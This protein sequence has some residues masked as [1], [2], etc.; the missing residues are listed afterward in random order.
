MRRRKWLRWVAIVAVL[1]FAASAVFSRV[2]QTA[3]ARRY[4]ITRLAASFGRP[5]EVAR[6]DFSLLDGARL[7]AHSLTVSED[8]DFGNEYF[9]RAETL[10]A[11]LRW[12][13]LLSGR[14]EFGSLN[15]LRSSLNLV[16]DAEGHWNIER[17]LPPASSGASRP[18]FVGP[19]A[20]SSGG[21]VAR[22]SRID[23][24][25]GRINFKQRDDKSPFALLDVAGRVERDNAGHWQLDL[26]ARPMRAGTGLQ[27]IGMLRLRGTIAGT[28]ARLQPADLNLTWRAASAAD[29]LRLARQDDYGIRGELALDLN[30]RVGPTAPTSD[31]V[32]GSGGAQWSISGVA[33]LTGIHAW[34]LPGRTTDPAVNISL[35]AGWR[36]GEARAQ[37]RKLLVE[38]QGSH[39]EGTGDVDWARGLRPQFHIAS[40]TLGLQDV[41]SWYRAFNPEVADDLRAE[42]SLGVDVTLGGWPIQLQQG[43]IASAGGTLATKS[44]PAPIRI[45]AV[46]AG[47]SHGG[48]DFTPTE[49]SFAPVSPN[50]AAGTDSGA[51]EVPGTFLLRGSISPH[52]SGAFHWPPDWNFFIEG[53]TSRVQDWLALSAA[54]AQPVN[55][56]WTAEGGLSIKLRGTHR[57][58]LPATVWL[59]AMDFRALSLSPAYVNQPVRLLKAHV[60][61]MPAQQTITLSEAEAL[62][63]TWHGTLSRKPAAQI[64]ADSGAAPH[65]QWT[66][67]LT[68]DHLDTAELD[69]WLGPRAR[70]G[71][72]A[73]ITSFGSAAAGTPL[74]GAVTAGLAAQGRLRVAEIVMTPLRLEQFDGEVDLDGRTVKVRKATADFFGGKASGTFDASLISDPTYDFQGRFDRVNLGQLGRASPLLDSRIAGTSSGT[75]SLSTHGVGREALFASMEG[76]GTID[77]RNAEIHGLDFTGVFRGS[78]DTQDSSS[79]SFASIAGVFQIQNRGITLS[80]FVLNHSQGRLQADGR[81]DFSHAL[82]IRIVRSIP[83]AGAAPAS[84]APSGFLL[85]GTIENPKLV[86]ATPST[87]PAARPSSR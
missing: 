70:P 82:N 63:A 51:A 83:Q 57:T 41:L 35:D 56:G 79:S 45:G 58:D 71:F 3:A 44:L 16:R 9:L 54:L 76:K 78:G 8:P 1:M 39:L 30:A 24:D 55:S 52:T 66:F 86:S 69:R 50:A 14:F 65:A 29:A 6:F 38:M 20:V 84:G 10:T 80:N 13:A 60:E 7:E 49:F 19:L 43:A 59:G 25:A 17:W 85:S 34:N 2:L 68:A 73:R 22:L 46:N 18:G 23:V 77:A 37:V 5:V 12:G 21:Q 28:S 27:D 74:P 15:L 61:Y 62:G 42:G 4:L 48:L 75:L 53:A 72:L 40:S 64:A 26:E 47:V 32:D 11:G 67:D 36:L 33:R 87:K 31:S 81:I